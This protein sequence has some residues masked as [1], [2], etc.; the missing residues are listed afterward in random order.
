MPL[1]G[2]TPG[3]SGLRIISGESQLLHIA[4]AA[5]FALQLEYVD[6]PPRFDFDA[7]QA[8]ITR[9]DLFERAF[10][11]G[12]MLMGYHL[13]F[14]GLGH[15]IQPEGDFYWQPIDPESV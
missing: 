15:V 12:E 9:R 1:P 3:H 14:P 6:N 4:D 10:E 11:S 13:P 5:H 8:I 7:A 2:H